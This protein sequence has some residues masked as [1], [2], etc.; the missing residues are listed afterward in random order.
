MFCLCITTHDLCFGLFQFHCFVDVKDSSPPMFAPFWA[1]IFIL[2]WIEH[3]L[4]EE[5]EK[6][7]MLVY[8]LR[9]D[10]LI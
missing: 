8:N 3:V 2:F 1:N 6:N 10:N 4:G 9:A 5:F 7:I